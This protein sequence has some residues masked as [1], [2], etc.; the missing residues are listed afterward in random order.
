[1]WITFDGHFTK[2]LAVREVSAWRRFYAHH[3]LLCVWLS[4]TDCVRSRHASCHRCAGA[5]DQLE[6]TL[7]AENIVQQGVGMFDLELTATE[8]REVAKLPEVD[9][10]EVPFD[11]EEDST[12]TVDL[13]AG[14]IQKQIARSTRSPGSAFAS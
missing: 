11:D 7:V 5:L 9:E 1:M 14:L 12:L 8:L 10:V 13:M 2:E 3:H 4:N 6:V